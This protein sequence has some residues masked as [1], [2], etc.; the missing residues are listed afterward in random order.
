[1]SVPVPVRVFVS[2]H[3]P[4][5]ARNPDAVEQIEG[6]FEMSTHWSADMYSDREPGIW[7][8]WTP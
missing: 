5:P 8:L 1:M 3:L 4:A 6:K 2:V 7:R